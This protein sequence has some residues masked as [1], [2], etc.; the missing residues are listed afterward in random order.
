MDNTKVLQNKQW[1]TWLH[2][3]TTK[4][5]HQLPYKDS[6]LFRTE[7]LVNIGLSVL[8]KYPFFKNNL[9]VHVRII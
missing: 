7:L 5:T 8:L 4:Y 2:N 3:T 1:A 9:V 6:Q